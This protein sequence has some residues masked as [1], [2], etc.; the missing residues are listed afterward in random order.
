MRRLELFLRRGPPTY[1]FSGSR[2]LPTFE[3]PAVIASCFI[4]TVRPL[5]YYEKFDILISGSID[6]FY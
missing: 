1:V 3:L 4:A 5:I 2:I 6:I